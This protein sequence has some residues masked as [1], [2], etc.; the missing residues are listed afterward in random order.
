MTIAGTFARKQ[1]LILD[2]AIQIIEA[3][4]TAQVSMASLAKA[5]GLSR[6]S[7][8]QYFSSREHVL[9][10]L[11]LNEMADLSNEIER[12]GIEIKEPMERIRVWVHYSLAHLS[13]KQH[14][15]VRQISIDTLPED[16]RGMLRAMH[17]Y[18]MMNLI[19]PLTELG[20][21]D[22]AAV[23]SIIYGAVASAAKRIGEG[24]DFSAEAKALEKFVSAG[25]S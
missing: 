22:P 15:I 8:Y 23:C 21:E 11:M 5:T 3:G 16:Q 20:T 18:F 4:G 9:G 1:Q 25:L 19:S 10:E 24:A 12:L 13:S 2:S 14:G 7:V 6:P 17:G